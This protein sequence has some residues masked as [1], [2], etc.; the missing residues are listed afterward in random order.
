M[1]SGQFLSPN[2]QVR[3]APFEQSPRP[4]VGYAADYRDGLI[5]GVHSHPKAQLLYA[6]SGVMRV[7]AED[8]FFTVPPTT[9]LFVQPGKAHSVRMQGCVAQRQLFITSIA[10]QTTRDVEVISMSP[11]L[12]ELV[13]ELCKEGADWDHPNRARQLASLTISELERADLLPFGLPL[14]RDPRVRRIASSL[15]ASPNDRRTLVDWSREAG[16]SERTL[17]RL[18]LQETGMTFRQWRQHARL[19]E[20]YVAL[21]LGARPSAAARSA[22][23]DSAPAF[24]AAFRAR[25][26]CTPGSLRLYR[27]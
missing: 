25:F 18:F 11:L 16:A 14:P 21:T 9:A 2:R 7:E 12:R 3:L 5:T 19:M 27:G 15:T 24:G 10:R 23:Y 17:A 20:A 13:V 6:V 8:A 4:V 26:G 22:G 1:A